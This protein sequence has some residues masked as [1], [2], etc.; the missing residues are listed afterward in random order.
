MTVLLTFG[1]DEVKAELTEHVVSMPSFSK[2]AV[3]RKID[4]AEFTDENLKRKCARKS[5]RKELFGDAWKEYRQNLSS[6]TSDV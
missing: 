4:L 3:K 2:M 1:Q 6:R 5:L